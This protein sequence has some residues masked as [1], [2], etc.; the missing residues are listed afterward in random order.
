MLPL[1]FAACALMAAGLRE[2]GLCSSAQT[3]LV[4]GK[5]S[6]VC[7]HLKLYGLPGSGVPGPR[8]S[9]L[10]FSCSW[11]L[12]AGL[13]RFRVLGC[14]V[15]AGRVSFSVTGSCWGRLCRA[16]GFR[17]VFTLRSPGSEAL[18]PIRCPF[19]EVQMSLA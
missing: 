1:T 8:L 9:R 19:L 16:D 6:C 17:E 11:Q 3:A 13:L 14:D 5:G 2:G 15:C 7:S 12:P 18:Q 4:L 10:G